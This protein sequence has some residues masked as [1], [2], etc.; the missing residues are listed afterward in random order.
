[1]ALFK[2][3]IGL[4]LLLIV[5][6]AYLWEFHFKPVSGPI[7]TAAVNEYKSRDYE[8]SLQLLGRA[9][10]FDPNN[11]GILTL[12]GWDY[13]KLGRPKPALEKF[14]R[15]HR[16]APRA[17]DTILGYATTEIELERCENA[18]RLLNLLREQKVDSAEVRMA[19]EDLNRCSQRARE[20]TK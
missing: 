2:N 8:N 18:A 10:R 17:P 7:Y 20:A 5:F 13:L 1:M 16:L 4:S 19:W 3:R 14:S 9:Y 15:A 6:F 11:I 12:M